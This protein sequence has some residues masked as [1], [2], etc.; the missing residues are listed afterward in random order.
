MVFFDASE[1][2]M[3]EMKGDCVYNSCFVGGNQ[4][5]ITCLEPANER[6]FIFKLATIVSS[7]SSITPP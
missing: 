1:K 6:M 7:F 2:L 5:Y 3:L 4:T